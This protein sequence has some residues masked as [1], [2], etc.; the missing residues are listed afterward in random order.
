M[1]YKIRIMD[2]A[3]NEMRETYWYIAEQLNNPIAAERRISLIDEAIRS[4]KENPG[5]FPL[6][7]DKYLASK[8]YRMIVVKNHLVFFIVREEI[9]TVSV[10]R[11]L[12]G[13]R[14]WMHLL[15]VEAEHLPEAGQD[16][17]ASEV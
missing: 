7:R 12:Y 4:L 16:A 6:V 8:G 11:V 15:R 13:R 2:P 3:Q 1:I 17:S 14:D 9:K 10:M 5:R